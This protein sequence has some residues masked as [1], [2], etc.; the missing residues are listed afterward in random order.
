MLTKSSLCYQAGR[1]GGGETCGRA[2]PH[3]HDHE[4]PAVRASLRKRFLIGVNGST[5][6]TRK[7]L[8]GESFQRT[9][10]A[11][12]KQDQPVR[13]RW[14]RKKQLKGWGSDL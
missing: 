3:R 14:R 4:R 7:G 5:R 12:N 9:Y 8:D 13:N 10:I 2:G 1:G 6:C 11:S